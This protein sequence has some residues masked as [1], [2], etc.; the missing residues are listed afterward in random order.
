MSPKVKYEVTRLLD[1]SYK[2]R[3]LG[4]A[5]SIMGPFTRA[6]LEEFLADSVAPSLPR[7]SA[8]SAGAQPVGKGGG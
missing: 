8:E 1:K 4:P 7:W 2:L 3:R 5:E 6:E